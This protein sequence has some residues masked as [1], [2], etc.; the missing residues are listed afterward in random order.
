MAAGTVKGHMFKTEHAFVWAFGIGGTVI[1]LVKLIA[2]GQPIL[3]GGVASALGIATMLLYQ[4][5]QKR[6]RPE[7]DQ[8]RL[9]DEVY[10]LGLLYT[11]TSLCVALLNLFLL[12]GNEQSLEKRTN[13]M[14]GSFGIA[15]LTTMAGIVLRMTLQRH[16]AERQEGIILPP[17]ASDPPGMGVDIEG[18][19]I[20]LERYAYELRRQLNNSANAFASH[21]NK[22]ILQ[23][24][25]THAHMTEMMQS[26][27][28]GLEEKAKAQLENLEATYQTVAEQAEEARQ[29][30]EEQGVGIKGVLETLETNVRNLDE[31]IERIRSGSGETAENLAAIALQARAGAEAFA[32]GGTTVT[33][34]LLSLAE[35]THSERTA[36]NQSSV[37][38][39]QM[40]DQQNEVFLR[41]HH[42]V[43]EALHQLAQTIK[44]LADLQDAARSTNTELAVLPDGVRRANTALEYQAEGQEKLQEDLAKIEQFATKAGEYSENLKNTNREIQR[45]NTNLEG[46]QNTLQEEGKK[47]AEVVAVA[48]TAVD[49]AKDG[50]HPGRIKRLL[51]W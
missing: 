21:A 16:G 43:L 4:S 36:R 29:R 10:Y 30:T 35:A 31:S 40:A 24:K 38:R 37:E 23:A 6:I 19:T 5:N 32:E 22:T 1:L 47:F 17:S 51:G 8:P 26:F 46:M 2:Q 39:D 49:K 7:S 18:G 28:N 14:I 27:H 3:G 41:I 34:G 48:I 11:L 15:L 9:G 33:A 45:I 25:T 20:D 44:A 50:D 12:D 13:E 42:Q